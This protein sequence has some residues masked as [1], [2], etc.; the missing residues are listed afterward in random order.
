MS[1]NQDKPTGTWSKK[2]SEESPFTKWMIWM[3]FLPVVNRHIVL[4][5]VATTSF[6]I[7][8]VGVLVIIVLMNGGPRLEWLGQTWF[9]KFLNGS[10][11]ISFL[12]LI[13]AGF[14]HLLLNVFDK[15][16]SIFSRIVTAVVIVVI[17]VV[18]GLAMYIF[19]AM[20]TGYENTRNIYDAKENHNR[21]RDFVAESFTQCAS[22]SQYIVLKTNSSGGTGNMPCNS[23]ANSFR[24]LF[25]SHFNY[26][27]FVNPHN[28]SEQCCYSSNSNRPQL[29]R[30]FIGSSGNK[31]LINTNVGTDSGGNSY[32][33][34]SVTKE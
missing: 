19:I 6:I 4:S 16:Y 17:L 24:I 28:T 32:L 22:G 23:S 2:R 14:L 33:S 8:F 30:T 7:L 27:G 3:G 12:V 15:R 5:R 29:G 21:I 11:T 34:A 26:D 31:I 13:C 25:T 20:R 10:A 18:F 9:G 1:N